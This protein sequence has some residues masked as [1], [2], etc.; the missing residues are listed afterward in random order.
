[1]IAL[2]DATW[3]DNLFDMLNL[4]AQGNVFTLAFKAENK[5]VSV[6]GDATAS[7][8]QLLL[9]LQWKD[10]IMRVDVREV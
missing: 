6:S 8:C 5:L 3:T 1:M 7:F 2:M 4:P 9:D 10:S